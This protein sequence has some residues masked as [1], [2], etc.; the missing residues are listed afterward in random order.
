MG[1][2]WGW[3]AAGAFQDLSGHEWAFLL[4]IIWQST[5]SIFLVQIRTL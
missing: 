5:I 1:V 3:G 2:A 4:V